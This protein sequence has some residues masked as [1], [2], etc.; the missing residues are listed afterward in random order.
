[1]A[2]L[3]DVPWLKGPLEERAR[4][5]AVTDLVPR[6][7]DEVKERFLAQLDKIEA[8]VRERMRREIVHLQHRALEVEADERAGKKPRL[9]S[10][11]IRRQAEALTDRLKLRL[12]DIARQRDIAPMGPT[13]CGAALVL[14]A[15]LLSSED[16]SSKG[17]VAT[18][19]TATRAEVE[20]KAMRAVMER[21]RS[22]GRKPT[23]VSGEDRGYD[24]ESR[25]PKTGRLRFIEVKGRRA[26]ARTITITRNEMLAAFNATESFI[27]AVV[28]VDGGAVQEPLYVPDPAPIFGPEPGFNEVSRAISAEAITA[29]AQRDMDW[30]A[31]EAAPQTDETCSTTF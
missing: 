29:A 7:L 12:A 6:H 2:E 23:D 28:F 20:A 9:N 24:I 16:T 11:K 17:A 26:D 27:L 8:A 30:R 3:V 14:P 13:I 25:D 21:E 1:M 18:A 5:L 19:D 10:E 22:V 4:T 31:S 15:R